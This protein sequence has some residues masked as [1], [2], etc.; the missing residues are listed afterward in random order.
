MKSVPIDDEEVAAMCGLPLEQTYFDYADTDTDDDQR[1]VVREGSIVRVLIYASGRIN[2]MTHY[3]AEVVAKAIQKASED[4]KTFFKAQTDWVHLQCAK[5]NCDLVGTL[6]S[7]TFNFHDHENQLV[8]S[9]TLKIFAGHRVYFIRSVD[10]E[11][12]EKLLHSSTSTDKTISEKVAGL[13][14]KAYLLKQAKND[15]DVV[16]SEGI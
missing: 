12:T 5:L 2:D 13:E 6:Q 1:Y 11:G 8:Y 7:S 15:D 10:R 4:A 9:V 14:L 3:E 16:S